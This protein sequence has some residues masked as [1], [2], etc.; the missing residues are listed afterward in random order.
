[1]EQ[2]HILIIE[3]DPVFEADVRQRLESFEMMEV[4]SVADGAAGIDTAKGRPPDLI[5]LAAE[6]PGM[7][8]YS[9]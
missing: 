9:V 7:S 3:N 1:M 6:L 2:K 5:L 8:G 4:T